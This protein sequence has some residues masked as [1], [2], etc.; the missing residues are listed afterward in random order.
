MAGYRSYTAIAE[1]VD[2][3]PAATVIAVGI[4]PDRPPSEAVIRRLPQAVGLNPITAVI[5]ARLTGQAANGQLVAKTAIAVDGKDV[6]WLTHHG[7][8]LLPRPRRLRPKPQH[9]ACPHR[10]RRQGH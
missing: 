5:G 7:H 2:D 9:R 10:H 4:D 1:C 3:V 8:H 6:A